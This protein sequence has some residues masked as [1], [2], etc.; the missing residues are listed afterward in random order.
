M[1][2]NKIKDLL[3]KYD[4]AETSLQEEQWLAEYF[5]TANEIPEE[6]RAYQLMFLLRDE[7]KTR[8]LSDNFNQRIAESLTK[9]KTVPQQG[10]RIQLNFWLTRIAAGMILLISAV[11]FINE[12]KT[13]AHNAP[14][15]AV[16]D[17]YEDPEE[18][19]RQTVEALAFLSNK[20][21]KGQSRAST[22]MDKLK[23][24]DKVIPN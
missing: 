9:E 11:W 6:W 8:K 24:L 19:Y 13:P 21:K 23:T 12:I 20:W 17:T 4:Q 1:D 5:R 16:T 10:K 14:V 18:A 2:T 3:E 7:L 22:T 15:V